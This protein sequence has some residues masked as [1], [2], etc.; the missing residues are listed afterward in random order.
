MNNSIT[1]GGPAF[2][3]MEKF[4]KW[5]EDQAQYVD[6][7]MPCGGMTLHQWYAGLAM[8]SLLADYD[9]INVYEEIAEK[10]HK[11][12]DAMIAHENA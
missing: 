6:S 8:Q 9:E 10:A 1:D 7:F 5:N 3:T 2:P 11:Q 12:A 4:S